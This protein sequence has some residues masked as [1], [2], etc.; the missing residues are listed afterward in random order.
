MSTHETYPRDLGPVIAVAL[1]AVGGLVALGLGA[2]E[3]GLALVL[4][5]LAGAIGSSVGP[6]L[7]SRPRRM[8]DIV[9]PRWVGADDRA[10]VADQRRLTAQLADAEQVDAVVRPRL[11]AVVADRLARRGVEVGSPEARRLLGE[12][13]ATFLQGGGRAVSPAAF[14]A[15][16]DRVEAL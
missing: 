7:A 3:L 5:A 16:L 12:P 4:L 13:L 9:V 15:L 6:H 14:R 8:T 10:L 1:A 11:A 2:P